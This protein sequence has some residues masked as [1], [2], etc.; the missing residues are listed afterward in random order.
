[1]Y[2]SEL[3]A[4]KYALISIESRCLKDTIIYSDSRSAIEAIRSYCPRNALVCNIQFLLHNLIKKRISVVLCW[5][6]G[7][8]GLEG[9]EKADKAAKEAITF[10]KLTEDLPVEDIKI[11]VK[12]IVNNNWQQEWQNC[13]QQNKLRAIKE[14]VKAWNSSSQS[15]RRDEVI[16]TRLRIGHTNITHSFLM[17]TPHEPPPFCNTCQVQLT[18]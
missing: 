17:C 13:P 12:N 1:M 6:P 3:Y 15:K 7:H 9:N 5:I 18:V 16:L 8:V 14:T 11:H 10:P 2:T 4:I